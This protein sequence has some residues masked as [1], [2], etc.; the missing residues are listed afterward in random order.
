[1][2]NT[3]RTAYYDSVGNLVSSRAR[4]AKHYAK[5]WFLLDLIS[6]VPFDLL[7]E[8]AFSFLSMLKVGRYTWSRLE[9]QSQHYIV[10]LV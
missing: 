2:I 5:T 6:V 1:L 10:R 4:I 7:T 3:C 9:N 8:G